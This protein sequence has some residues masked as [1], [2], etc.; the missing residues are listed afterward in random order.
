MR[1]RREGVGVGERI[2]MRKHERQEEG[3]T[4]RGSGGRRK[5]GREVKEGKQERSDTQ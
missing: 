5:E 1:G 4:E 2:R 3:I